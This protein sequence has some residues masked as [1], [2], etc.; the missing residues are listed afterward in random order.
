MEGADKDVKNDVAAMTEIGKASD[1]KGKAHPN[2]SSR[3]TSH[4][5]GG[6]EPGSLPM[7][8]TRAPWASGAGPALPTTA[9]GAARGIVPPVSSPWPGADC[10]AGPMPQTKAPW[11]AVPS[12]GAGPMPPTRAPWVSGQDS[13]AGP[14]PPTRAPW[15]AAPD[16]GAGPMPPTRAPWATGA[17]P[18]PP[19]RAPLA[20]EGEH[21]AGARPA[22][23][24]GRQ[25]KGSEAVHDAGS[26]AKQPP[27]IVPGMFGGGRLASQLPNTAAEHAQAAMPVLPLVGGAA[28]VE[29]AGFRLPSKFIN[30]KPD[31][32]LFHASLTGQGLLGFIMDINEAL[33]GVPLS[34]ECQVS[35]HARG[36]ISMLD[37]LEAWVDEIP[38]A[39][40]AMRYGNTA[41]REWHRRLVAN[42]GRLLVEL[43]PSEGNVR[44]AALELAPYM[45]DSFGNSVR[46]DYGTGHET[47]FVALLYCLAKLG[48]F[49]P[50]DYQALGTRVFHRY[51]KLMRRLQTTYLLE[52]AGSHGVW[53]LDD[54]CF[55]P[56]LW[57]SS[58]LIGHP[59]ILPKSIHSAE[60]M[61]AHADDY[62]YLASVQVG[63]GNVLSV[64]S[65]QVGGKNC[66]CL[67]CL[68][69]CVH[70]W[71]M[72]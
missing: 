44:A 58:Q 56:F 52:P 19:T 26:A 70:T 48:V 29:A 20:T 10:G 16:S 5:T 72:L 61:T 38:P 30:S 66:C 46:I 22:G 3:E 69:L 2:E 55:L 32:E 24:D 23:G 13:A 63:G 35:A 42:A 9:W 21:A 37:E 33:R 12:A 41:F 28:A 65:V 6:A 71:H 45:V 7:P 60:T 15:A 1:A 53:G 17:G 47:T 54:Y 8:P 59:T 36:V 49:K 18:M 34:A 67:S 68:Q 64:A 14:M 4:E 57:G 43:L 62:F 50:E 51:L 39:T 27:V 25:L 31:L 11:A 40:Q